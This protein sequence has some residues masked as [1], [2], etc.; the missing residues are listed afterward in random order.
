MLPEINRSNEDENVRYGDRDLEELGEDSHLS[1]DQI[2]KTLEKF[3]EQLS[4]HPKYK[5]LKKAR[6]KVKGDILPRQ[7]K[8]DKYHETLGDR[9]SLSKTDPDA[10]FMR[11][12]KDHMRNGQLKPGYNIQ[13]T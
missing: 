2:E 8:Y 3:E 11:M 6:K 1:T 12:K 7:Q 10:T 9:N 4:Q 13:L 5:R